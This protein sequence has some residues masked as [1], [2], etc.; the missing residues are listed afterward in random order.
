M[1]ALR[2]HLSEIELVIG[3]MTERKANVKRA[4][5]FVAE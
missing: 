4:G 5:A 3:V 1:S 2:K